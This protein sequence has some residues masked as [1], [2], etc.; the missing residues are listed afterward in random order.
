MLATPFGYAE[1]DEQ[2]I[3]DYSTTENV[4]IDGSDGGYTLT[5][6]DGKETANFTVFAS[7]GNTVSLTG[8]ENQFTVNAKPGNV[9]I[10]IEAQA[11][12]NVIIGN[13]NSNNVMNIT[14]DQW[15]MGIRAAG[16][17]KIHK[18]ASVTINGKRLCIKC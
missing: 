14:S 12:S 18:G 6:D 7:N 3:S 16:M 17:I 8:N 5:L 1:A 15:I 4:N 13:E 9:A 2:I 10:G 11:G